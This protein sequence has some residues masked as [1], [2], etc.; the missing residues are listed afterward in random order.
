MAASNDNQQLD[1]TPLEILEAL[2]SRVEQ[3]FVQDVMS[4]AETKLAN[5]LA[6][7][8]AVLVHER[9]VGA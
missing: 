3:I 7:L 6:V 1:G 5:A 4:P 9:K 8:I 2:H